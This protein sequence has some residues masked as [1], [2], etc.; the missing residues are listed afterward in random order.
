MPTG[1]GKR[2]A[3]GGGAS[4]L[5]GGL[6]ALLFTDLVGSTDLL[7]RLGDG[8]AEAIRREHFGLLRNAIAA[9]R[10]R[11]VKTLGDGVMAVFDSAVEAVGCAVEVQKAAGLRDR[12]TQAEPLRIR[13]G[14]HVGEPI[15]D[16][17]DFFGTA[18]VI[19]RRLCDAAGG[20][21]ILASDLVRGLVEPRREHCF[22]AVGTVPL[23][24]LRESMPAFEV[25][26][27]APRAEAPA[28]PPP[29]QS[30][31]T[32]D[33]AP[34]T[35][36][37]APETPPLLAR[38]IY[39]RATELAALRGLLEDG[40]DV[41]VMALVGEAGI[42]KTRLA[43]WT[44]DL[45]RERG[46]VVVAGG[47]HLGLPEPLG[48]FCDAVR[49]ARR[50]GV[51]PSGDDPLAVGFPERLLPELG[52]RAGDPAEQGAT[53]EAAVRYV[54]AIAADGG[55]LL[56]LEDL[57]WADP[58]SL[59]LAGLLARALEG[60]PVALVVT[61]RPDDDAGAAALEGFRHELRRMRAGELA[62]GPLAP[63]EAAAM[64]EELLG[65]RPDE[66]V[67]TELIR[68]SG[69]NPFALEELARA[70]VD[71]G[72]I[73]LETG[74]RRSEVA[75]AVPW[76]LAESIRARSSR[77]AEPER[78]LIRW[79]AVIGERF[80]VRLLAAAAEVDQDAALAGL[81]GCVAAGLVVED[82]ADAS[83]NRFAFRHALVHEA[84][85][86]E[87]LVAERARRHAAVLAAAER[88]ADEGVEIS[89]AELA[90]HAVGAGDRR[91]TVVHSAA[92][93]TRAYEIG[94]VEEAVAH[95]E[96]ALEL[97]SVED[98]EDLRADLLLECG[99]LRARLS[100]G[101]ERAVSLLEAAREAHVNLGH[102]GDAARALALLADARFEVG[103]RDQGL[104]DWGQALD[105]LRVSG[106]AEAIPVA[107][108]G[109]A[110][111]RGLA[112]Q[113]PEGLAAA[114]EG[115]AL[116][117]GA[118]DA[119]QARTRV[120]LLTTKGM[121]HLLEFDL[122]TARPLLL[123]AARLAVEHQDDVGAARA[124]H[125]LG[126][127]LIAIPPAEAMSHFARAAELVRR[128][129]L[130]G[131]EAWYLTLQGW[132]ATNA[133]DWAAA[134]RLT[135]EAAAML[136]EDERAAWTRATIAGVRLKRLTGLGELDRC[137]PAVEDL[138]RLVAGIESPG[139]I[140]EAQAQAAGIAFLR[141]EPERASGI[142]RPLVED[143]FST[144][145]GADLLE[146]PDWLV[147]TEVLAA[148]GALADARRVAALVREMYDSPW[149]DH[150]EAVAAVDELE[151]S[152]VAGRIEAAAS[153]IEAGGHRLEPA[154]MRVAASIVL[155]GRP[156]G[157]HAAAELARAAHASF[158][159][160][161][162]TAWCRRLEDNLRSLGE[163]LPRRRGGGA[164][165]LTRRELEVLELLAEGLTNRA[166]AER[167]VISEA[168]AIRHVA[169]IYAKLGVNR[170]AAAVR[171]A[172]ERGLIGAGGDGHMQTGA[173]GEDT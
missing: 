24:G 64:L 155:A 37:S 105:E 14:V 113:L 28:A 44:A 95:L 156:E 60:E 148:T 38:T 94:A 107:L 129:G 27:D 170:R 146:L 136:P 1:P 20:G 173:G 70:V 130:A 96:R 165:G 73:D 117:P 172:T 135:D 112:I 11:E 110:R 56:V 49:R 159:E 7:E 121:I 16:E 98:G 163:P 61:F 43:Q 75:V 92:A 68:L 164:G 131:L 40:G 51:E 152:E 78:E 141:R 26:W 158:A 18:V 46:R 2:A 58:S 66:E 88:L 127:N 76:T 17:D 123:E 138:A 29:R 132:A 80:D 32:R 161:G 91:R 57:H 153:A 71:S 128:H 108:A 31:A 34:R 59:A 77:L 137:E 41:T 39:G 65:R 63:D 93:A 62:L 67:A 23:K 104:R 160:L 22:R 87:R 124:H 111:G 167:L 83:G 157:A 72:W 119:E 171:V 145:R 45:A 144:G 125:I 106:P 122:D 19:A 149:A 154:R 169:N 33:D 102:A 50:A 9:T 147:V 12:P 142:V 47:T 140:A 79:A 69:G 89:S 150:A 48:V 54:R 36:R 86:Q 114:D 162:S 115:L 151:P 8:A 118:A 13:I 15:H 4:A 103:E 10:G 25:S 134:Q 133:G 126:T 55:L 53:F 97:W 143:A 100:R 139:H 42:G 30:P 82:A 85:V 120:S 84:L 6:V 90:R 166:I 3:G 101:D 81:A 5:P 109:L 74:A 168:T 116:L 52:A 21:Q 35:R 99:R